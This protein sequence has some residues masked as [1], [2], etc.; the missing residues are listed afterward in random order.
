MN[1]FKKEGEECLV[2]RSNSVLRKQCK[3]TA[4]ILLPYA[5]ARIPTTGD[6]RGNL[7]VDARGE[8]R[9]PTDRD[10]WICKKVGL[11]LREKGLCM[12]R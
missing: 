6:F 5:L 8:G 10:L 4:H 7:A 1:F 12:V 9:E 11:T 2:N 3:N